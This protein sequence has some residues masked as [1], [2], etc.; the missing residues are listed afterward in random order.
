MHQ[1]ID[2]W[3]KFRQ[4]LFSA[5]CLLCAAKSTGDMGICRNC[6][7]DMPWHSENRCPQCS[8]DSPN[9][10]LC[11]HCLKS[12]PAFDKTNVL[13]RY[14][15]PVNA[16]LRHYKYSHSL[17]LAEPFGILLAESVRKIPA[18][19]LV[20]P[21]PLHPQRL[22]E[23]GF[24]QAVEIARV[25]ARELRLTMDSQSCSRIKPT[26]PQASLPLKERVKNMKDAFDCKSRLDGLRIALIDDVM[27]TGASLDALAET[28]KMAG[29]SHVECWGI[30]RTL[31]HQ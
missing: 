5:P 6:L 31:S 27:T 10:Q 26:P 24:N 19:D 4:S 25:V 20:M 30:A 16:L 22:R 7:D 21:M 14:E 2:I 23:R 28:V 13:F 3:Q 11:G 18:P 1:Q 15:Y 9:N 17:T 12:P 29:A 8:L